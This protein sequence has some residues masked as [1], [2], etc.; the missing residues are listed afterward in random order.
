MANDYTFDQASALLNAVLEQATGKKAIAALN[1]AQ[2]VAQANTVLK[3]GTENALDA[4][5][6]VLARTAF[7]V[8]PYT[9]KFG[10][11]SRDR[12]AWGNHIRKL[13]AGDLPIED[14]QEY[15]HTDGAGIDQYKVRKPKVLQ[16]NF[17]GAQ[18]GQNHFTVYKDQLKAGLSGPDEF[19]S[20]SGLIMTNMRDV[21]EQTHEG[22]RRAALANFVAGKT[23]GD[24][25]S[26]YHLLTLYNAQMGTTLTAETVRHTENYSSFVRWAYAFIETI[27]DLMT[28]RTGMFHVTPTG[29]DLNRHTPYGNQNVFVLGSEINDIRA[30]VLSATFSPEYLD[31]AKFEKVNFWQSIKDRGT[32]KADASWLDKNGQVKS[33]KDVTVSHVFAVIVDDEAVGQTTFDEST[34]TSPYNA[35]GKYYNIYWHWTDRYW[36]DFT[37]NGAVFLLD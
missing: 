4:I 36:N 17:Y 10:S 26:V 19:M 37:E 8:R 30:E 13:S 3:T 32:I 23:Q 7:A 11:L 35:A 2:F 24:T 33:K 27:A 34:D 14:S 29:F 1:S 12:Q 21:L 6:A 16:T 9:A 22:M 25:D 31:I 5:S 20:L 15:G 28:E 18:I